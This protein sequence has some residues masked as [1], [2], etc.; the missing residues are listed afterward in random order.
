MSEL[1]WLTAIELARRVQRRTLSA[2]EV[3]RATL[4]RLEQLNPRLG[5]FITI[6]AEE[7]CRQARAV[8]RRLRAGE[9]LPLAGVPLGVKDI[10]ATR[11]VRTTSGARTFA[12]WVPDHDAAVVIRLRAAGAI[13]VG[14]TNLHEFAFGFTGVNPHFGAAR[15]PWDLDRVTGGSSSG[16]ASAVA[17]GLCPLAL[18]SDTGGSIRLPAAL[19][20]HVGLKPSYGL[21]SRFG[22]TALAWSM[23]HI[24]PMTRTVADAALMFALMAGRDERDATSIDH[25]VGR[26]RTGDL[27]GLRL[28]IPDN[29]F[30]EGADPEVAA[31]VMTATRRLRR[32][33]AR[34]VRVTVPH[35]PAIIAAH[36]AIIFPEAAA[37]HQGWRD[38]LPEYG[39][40]VRANILA[41]HLIPAET[42][43]TAQRARRRM[44]ADW[45]DMMRA[46]DMLAMPTALLPALEI[47]HLPVPRPGDQS[48]PLAR[49]YVGNTCPFNLLGWPALSLPCGFTRSGLPIGLQLAAGWGDDATVLRVA[50]AYERATDW[51]QRRPSLP[52]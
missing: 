14:K 40:D 13:M 29:Y 25:R 31:A 50:H 39:P 15:N 47:A 41:G 2:L 20:G 3:T 27:R 18:G 34:L 32:L 23:D 19:C 9:R 45:H 4:T 10:F 8:D 37:A 22:A 28:G 35:L 1:Q 36:R 21:V 38:R 16:S 33:G 5:A 7:A 42:Y 48:R 51:H 52:L 43:L 12:D 24:G 46:C 17:G 11:S 30:F 26:L 49:Q 6:T 44:V